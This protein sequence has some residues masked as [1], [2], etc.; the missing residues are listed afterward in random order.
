PFAQSAITAL[1]E[2]RLVAL[3]ER[4]EADLVLG[5]PAELV[6]E[7]EGLV[8]E[9]P[10]RERLRGHLMLALY[11]SERQ[12]EAL[13]V[14][15]EARRTL[16]E[17]LG[18]EPGAALQGLEQ[19]I[20][21]HDPTLDRSPAPAPAH[22]TPASSAAEA[23]VA[24]QPWLAQ[25]R[26]T[27]TVV[28]IDLS[29]SLHS[30][31]GSDH[32]ASRRV[33]ARCFEAT[34]RALNRHGGTVEGFIGGVVVAVFGVPT[35]HEDDALRAVRAAQDVRRTLAA[36]N[37]QLERDHAITLA[38]RVGVN[39][40]EVVVGDPRK[41]P[42]ASG[43]TV[44]LAARLQQAAAD[45]EVLLGEA[46]RRLVEDAVVVEPA[47]RPALDGHGQ[48]PVAWRLVDLIRGSPARIP[49]RDTP[50]VG[51][52]GEL[53]RIRKA[54][55]RVVR[56]QR[57][58]LV[59][60]VGEAGVGKSRLA[61][62]FVD[63][64]AGEARILIGRCPSYGEGITFWPLREVVLQAVG[65]AGRE[66]IFDLLAGEEEG[67]STAAQ[68]ASVIGLTEEPVEA[69]DLFPA[70]KHFVEALASQQPLVMV[71]DDV[72]W[73]QPTLL[74]LITYLATSA[75]EAV[76]LVCLARP[77]ILDQQGA[78]AHDRDDATTLML[79]PLG[80]DDS[81]K[82]VVE[83]LAGQAL[84]PETTAQIVETG[85]GN[86]LFLEQLIAAL[87]DR[88]ELTLPP[89]LQALLTA[90]LDRLG[91]AERDLL[92][93]ASVVGID[94]SVRALTAL[95]PDEARPFAGRHLRALEDRELIR[96]SRQP[97]LGQPAFSFRHVLIQLAAYRSMTRQTRAELHERFAG[98]LERA[99]RDSSLQFEA[100]IGYHLEQAYLHRR[101][102]GLADQH[103]RT[104][105]L[106]AGEHL[107]R[108]GGRAFGRFD[109]TAAENLW[110]RAVALLPAD[111]P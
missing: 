52:E 14:Y 17:E 27:V 86:P 72:H 80:G 44:S 106:R 3:E 73:A 98:W 38:A 24:M 97:F 48:Q 82:L 108:A 2:L 70:I 37:H 55:D 26:K 89:S 78:W 79:T 56:E 57:P 25:A 60:V 68:V 22:T 67:A 47:D 34:A 49:R 74:E 39:S 9:H 28:F 8:A 43:D 101:N 33:T 95:V 31:R 81:N 66:G 20:L 62:E 54:Y 21:R 103:T 83:Q 5:R 85:Q 6:A 12:A 93:C 109:V 100:L 107:A 19:A 45:G 30:G 105:A 104:L 88:G 15:R 77:E 35:A 94:F 99:A 40:G 65:D 1:E 71:L 63:T 18:I 4:I 13:E 69:V 102:L 11:R 16:V 64:L 75:E 32:E 90:R 7:L 84:S 87:G 51:R 41:G 10:F 46:T 50:L 53:S 96:P 23:S 36:M 61:L 58:A 91:P 92:R 29:E 111:H 59:S 76:L 110:S 42:T